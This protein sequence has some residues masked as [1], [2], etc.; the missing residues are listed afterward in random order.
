MEW[1]DEGVLL[2]S[3]PFGESSA[4]IDVFTAEH[5]RCSGVVRGGASR[6]MAPALQPGAQLDVAWSARLEEHLG[7]FRPELHHSR[8][9]A[10][11]GDR[12]TL[13]GLN[14]VTALLAFCLPE[15]EPHAD[16]YKRTQVVLELLSEPELWPIAYLRWEMNLL[17]DMGFGL[18]LSECAVTGSKQDLRYVSPKTGRA[19]SAEGA[20]A[21]VNK[22]LPLPPVM[23]RQGDG[24]D[25]EL[26][27][28]FHTIGF[29]LSE[30]LAAALGDRP[31]PEARARFVDVFRRHRLPK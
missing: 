13:A 12:L 16:L 30:H 11:M 3:R 4:I 6:R 8:A 23:L 29:F 2:S 25:E 17:E 5:G 14:T 10:A 15:R 19:V 24:S 18:D 28:A 27:Q 9:G 20:G 7:S 22:L 31:L 21:W 1:R 26:A